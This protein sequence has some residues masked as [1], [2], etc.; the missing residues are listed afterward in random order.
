MK[1]CNPAA[2]ENITEIL[3]TD[4]SFVDLFFKY[5]SLSNGKIVIFEFEKYPSSRHRDENLR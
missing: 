4:A 5:S 1:R 3:L 2:P